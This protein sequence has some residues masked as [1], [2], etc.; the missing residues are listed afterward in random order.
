VVPSTIEHEVST[1]ANVAHSLGSLIGDRG[2]VDPLF[3]LR[4]REPM[5]VSPHVDEEGLPF[6]HGIGVGLETG[7]IV[8]SLT[9]LDGDCVGVH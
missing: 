8:V 2:V 4:I 3:R 9:I 6:D 1:N 7:H 5:T